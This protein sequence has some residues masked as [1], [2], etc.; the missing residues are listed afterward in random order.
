MTA[1]SDYESHAAVQT[2]SVVPSRTPVVLA[3]YTL[4]LAIALA[5]SL[6]HLRRHVRPRR[7]PERRGS[8]ARGRP[9]RSRVAAR[10]RPGGDLLRVDRRRRRTGGA[11]RDRGPRSRTRLPLPR[12][13]DPRPRARRGREPRREVD[14]RV[15]PHR[16]H[17]PHHAHRGPSSIRS[18]SRSPPCSGLP[19]GWPPPPSR[20]SDETSDAPPSR[21]PRRRGRASALDR[22]ISGSTRRR[23]RCERRRG[24]SPRPASDERR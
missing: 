14:P 22:W 9:R 10:S 16:P 17:L 11:L 2:Y 3:K 4:V 20:S 15:I 8:W 21:A 24:S 7:R 5:V 6:G 18:R 19:H 1:T 23:G 13:A 12:A